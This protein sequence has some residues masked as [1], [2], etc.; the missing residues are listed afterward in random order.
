MPRLGKA[1]EYSRQ[2][3]SFFN[4]REMRADVLSDVGGSPACMRLAIPD[5]SPTAAAN[6]IARRYVGHGHRGRNAGGRHA[7]EGWSGLK[8]ACGLAIRAGQGR[9]SHDQQQQAD[10]AHWNSRKTAVQH[11]R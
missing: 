11:E 10:A 2:L 3:A 6:E 5:P 1:A 8:R 4:A 7:L 9:G